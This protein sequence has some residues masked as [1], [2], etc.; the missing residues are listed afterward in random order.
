[1]KI[2]VGMVVLMTGAPFLVFVFKKLLGGF[3]EHVLE[4][5]RVL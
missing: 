1:M 3:Q 2:A 4:L 5:V